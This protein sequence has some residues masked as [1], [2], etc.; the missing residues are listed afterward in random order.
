M[1]D[2]IPWGSAVTGPDSSQVLSCQHTKVPY[3][4]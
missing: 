4:I 2:D 3:L 1:K